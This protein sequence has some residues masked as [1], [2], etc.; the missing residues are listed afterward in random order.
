MKKRKMMMMT[1]MM[2]MMVTVLTHTIVMM[3]KVVLNFTSLE[4]LMLLQELF[5][6]GSPPHESLRI[7]NVYKMI[8]QML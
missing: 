4:R 7:M 8:T 3:T 5:C 2:M 6:K 1:M